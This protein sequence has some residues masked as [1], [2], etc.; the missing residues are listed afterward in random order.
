MHTRDFKMKPFLLLKTTMTSKRMTGQR[1]ASQSRLT[2]QNLDLLHLQY[3]FTEVT[4]WLETNNAPN[5]HK[6]SF[7][8]ECFHTRCF[9]QIMQLL[10]EEINQYYHQYLDT[11]DEG[12][13][14]LPYVTMQEMYFYLLLCGWITI[15]QTGSKITAP[16]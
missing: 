1:Q 9:L 10:L 12:H 16:Y 14:T 15:K 5:V 4:Q 6:D 8:T 11:L 7:P 3:R 2:V 13:S